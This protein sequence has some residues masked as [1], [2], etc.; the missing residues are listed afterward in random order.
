MPAVSINT[1]STIPPDFIRS[2]QAALRLQPLIFRV[3]ATRSP[4]YLKIWLP[5]KR[6]EPP[7]TTFSDC[8]GI[9]LTYISLSNS[10]EKEKLFTSSVSAKGFVLFRIILTAATSTCAI[11]RLTRTAAVSKTIIRQKSGRSGLYDFV[12]RISLPPAFLSCLEHICRNCYGGQAKTF[13]RFFITNNT[14]KI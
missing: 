1:I 14:Q 13:R 5:S 12:L 3:R 10:S 2:L 8:A 6:Q 9:I 4:T 11:L 7:M